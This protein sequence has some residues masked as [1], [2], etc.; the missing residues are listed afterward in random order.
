MGTNLNTLVMQNKEILS[1]FEQILGYRFTDLRLLQKALVHSSYAFEQAQL[2]KNNET[3]EFLGDAVLDLVIGH[4]LIKR[5]PEMREGELTKLRSALVNETHLAGMARA[6]ELGRFLCLGKGE[7]ACNGRNKS[8][9]LSCAYEAV[10]GSVFE[11]GGYET[12]TAFVERFFLPTIEGKKEALLIAD[13][14]S[15]LQEELQEQFNEAPVYQL[16][17]EE[18]PSHMKLFSISV[19]F[20]GEVLGSGTARSKKEAEQRAAADALTKREAAGQV[21][22]P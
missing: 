17:S 3:L 21:K 10:V 9:I 4:I 20:Q 14:K 19:V 16:D 8:S 7:D 13:A 11:D 6:I 15:R 5:Y 18:G 22:D 2:D 1:E 12:V